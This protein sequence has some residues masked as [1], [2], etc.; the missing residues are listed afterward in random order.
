MIIKLLK[1]IWLF[2]CIALLGM[3]MIVIGY[4]GTFLVFGVITGHRLY[5]QWHGPSDKKVSLTNLG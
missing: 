1:E 5:M 4:F 2:L 3:P